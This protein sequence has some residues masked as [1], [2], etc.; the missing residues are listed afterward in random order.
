MKVCLCAI[1]KNNYKYNED[2]IRHY[3]SLG[4]DKIIIY[5]NND[6][7]DKRKLKIPD[8]RRVKIENWRSEWNAQLKA[9][10]DCY[11]KHSN[12]YDWFAFFDSDEYLILNKWKSVKEM[13]ND[14]DD[15]DILAINWINY[16]D[17]GILTRD[18]SIPVNTFFTRRARKQNEFFHY[19]QFIRSG[20]PNMDIH[21]HSIVSQNPNIIR[22][23]IVHKIIPYEDFR[24]FTNHEEAFIK[25][26]P[27]KTLK[28]Y[29]EE[30]AFNG[31]PTGVNDKTTGK[32]FG[33]F[34][35]FNE[36]TPQKEQM[37][38]EFIETRN[39]NLKPVFLMRPTAASVRRYSSSPF[40]IV[41]TSDETYKNYLNR[42]SRI[43]IMPIAEASQTFENLE[44]I[45]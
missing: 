34:F 27:T 41:I 42:P 38:K 19:K 30:K 39:K 7:D 3:L 35:D 18:E 28:E 33:Y 32:S 11:K 23:N 8:I 14:F 13:L 24:T 20:I 9:Y 5:D 16:D 12:D 45:R 44:I 22:R 15:T 43:L 6:I 21:Q 29:I 25:H 10:E 36:R 26:V 4:F 40:G 17:M 1:V 31:K 2:W 37:I